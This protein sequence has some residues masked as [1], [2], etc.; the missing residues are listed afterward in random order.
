MSEISDKIDSKVK[1]ALYRSV[2]N[3]IN[4]ELSELE[5]KEILLVNKSVYI[6]SKDDDHAQLPKELKEIIVKQVDLIEALSCAKEK[7]KAAEEE[8]N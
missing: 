3:N 2:V 8:K 5:A 1:V 6:T 7:L 4:A